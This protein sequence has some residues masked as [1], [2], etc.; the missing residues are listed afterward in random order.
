M[1]L[2]WS[3]KDGNAATCRYVGAPR[4]SVRRGGQKNRWRG[5]WGNKRRN[6]ARS[7]S[8]SISWQSTTHNLIVVGIEV[9]QEDGHGKKEG[10]IGAL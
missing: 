4:K 6:R 10:V 7:T 5:S 9:G 1:L 3:G 2:A 8:G